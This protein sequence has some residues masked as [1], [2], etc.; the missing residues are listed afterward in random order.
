[1]RILLMCIFWAGLMTAADAPFAQS[2]FEAPLGGLPEGWRTWA[3][4]SEIAPRTFVDYRY[5]RGDHGSLAISGDNNPAEYGGWER[6]LTGIKE[7]Q[8]YR[9]A[10]YY[11]ATGLRYEPR[12]VIARLSWETADGKRAGRPDY[13]YA[14]SRDGAWTRLSM[15]VQAPENAAAVTI[16]LYLQNA[17]KATLWWDDISLQP[18]PDPG[19]RYVTIASLNY[20]PRK[21]TGSGI[22][23]IRCFIEAAEKAVSGKV[24]VILFPEATSAVDTGLS[25]AEVAELVP[26]PITALY[27]ELAR[28][29]NA[30]IIAGIDE[31]DGRAV[32]NTAVLIDRQGKVAGKYRKV[33]I[34]REEIE[35]GITPGNEYP[36]FSTDFGRIGIMICWDS[37]YPEPARALALGGAEIIFLPIWDGDQTLVKARA[38]E[39]HV[40]LAASSYGSP[41]QILDPGGEQ[42]A[43]ASKLGDAAIATIDL[44]RRYKDPWLGDMR[45]RMMKEYRGDV[46]IRRP[47]YEKDGR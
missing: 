5:S 20:R 39:N 42:L 46:Q 10:A 18:I 36:V 23:N 6:K 1:M 4:R 26:G 22:A 17:P 8:W 24:D 43:V 29:K 33:Y 45:A 25:Y 14:I 11:R 13:P 41:T 27:G 7:N 2:K 31:R 32:Y 37:E 21:K 38:I 28:R 16:Q 35:V 12:D 9:F 19:P 44:N 47:G 3:A 15:D 34:P 30:Y 40:F